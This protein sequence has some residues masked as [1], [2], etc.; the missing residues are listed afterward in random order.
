VER[1][2]FGLKSALA[3]LYHNGTGDITRTASAAKKAT[4]DERR[5]YLSGNRFARSEINSPGCRRFHGAD[6]SPGLLALA[7]TE[8]RWKGWREAHIARYINAQY[9]H[10]NA[11]R[12][13][14]GHFRLV[15]PSSRISNARDGKDSVALLHQAPSNHVPRRN[16][17]GSFLCGF[18]G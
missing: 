13:M 11:G 7:V 17:Q 15:T 10:G 16:F 2:T 4:R 14:A 9:P 6:I 18:R 3:S 12:L 8:G 5:Q 1:S